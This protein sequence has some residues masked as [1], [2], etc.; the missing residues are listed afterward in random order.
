MSQSL[1]CLFFALTCV[2]LTSCGLFGTRK[3]PS[4]TA[5]ERSMILEA[6]SSQP[7]RVF[8]ITNY[9]DSLLLRQNSLAV[10]PDPNDPVLQQF[11]A[12]LFRTVRDPNSLGVGIAAPQVGILKRI[13]WVQRFDKDGFP[14]EVYLNPEIVQYSELKQPCPEGC[15]SIP[16]FSDTTTNRAYAI[17]LAYD[18]M[19][20]SRQ[21]EMVEDFTAVI[22]QHEIDHLNGILFIDHLKQE[23]E[24]AKEN[25]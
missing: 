25:D 6:D 23:I 1:R 16:E 11:V 10:N 4:F 13:I 18:K 21:V 12:R 19:D 8:K 7:M 9:E 5:S 15:L 20:G 24:E 2:V 17:L 3:A 22:F 14:F